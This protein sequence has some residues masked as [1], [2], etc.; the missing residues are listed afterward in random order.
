MPKTFDRHGARFQYPENWAIEEEASDEGWTINLQSPATAFMTITY[1]ANVEEP[2]PLL[3]EA[4]NTLRE[5]YKELESE[6][7]QDTIAKSP[8]TGFDIN[9]IT[10]DVTSSCWIRGLQVMN[11]SLIIFC[12]CAD[13]EMSRNGLVMKAICTSLNLDD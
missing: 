6:E 7:V 8:A 12:Q 1:Y 9:F 4:L 3:E 10:L 2:E 5:I 11:G 13:R